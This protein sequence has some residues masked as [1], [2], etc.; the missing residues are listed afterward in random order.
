MGIPDLS[1]RADRNAR[2]SAPGLSRRTRDAGAIEQE[3]SVGTGVVASSI[4][5]NGKTL[6]VGAGRC[7]DEEVVEAEILEIWSGGE[8]EARADAEGGIK[9]EIRVNVGN[10]ETV[11]SEE[12]ESVVGEISV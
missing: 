11:E 7:V 8:G 4:E 1:A 9:Q 6:A 12:V 2:I 5:E 10:Q 3:S